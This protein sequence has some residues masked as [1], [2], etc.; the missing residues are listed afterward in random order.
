M[1]R[2]YDARDDSSNVEDESAEFGGLPDDRHEFYR[3][4]LR[5]YDIRGVI[6]ETLDTADARALGPAFGTAVS[7]AGGFRVCVGYDGRLS[8]PDLEVR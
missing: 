5:E 1:E 8:S 6:G 7:E 4:I 3:S 2:D